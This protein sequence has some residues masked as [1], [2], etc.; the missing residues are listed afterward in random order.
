MVERK[1]SLS[2]GKGK[3]VRHACECLI[4]NVQLRGNSQ[5]GARKPNDPDD[6]DE[7][8]TKAAAHTSAWDSRRKVKCGG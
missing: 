4:I 8:G 5:V 6:K 2:I 7:D 3:W 1:L